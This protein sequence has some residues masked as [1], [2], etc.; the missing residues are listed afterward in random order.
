[1]K[2]SLQPGVTRVKRLEVDASRTIAFMGEEG[3]VYATP[4]FVRDIEHACRDLLLEH[5]DPGEDSVGMGI[6]ITHLA[7]TLLGMHVEI[8]ATVS[9]IEGR[10]ITFEVSGK[11]DL[12]P[13]GSGTHTRFIVDVKKTHERLKSKAAKR[14]ASR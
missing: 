13:I 2:Q 10:K 7:P 1:M 4:D 11:D 5:A 14:D 8:T 3:R 9:A 12:E 6:A